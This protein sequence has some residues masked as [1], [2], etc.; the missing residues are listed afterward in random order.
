MCPTLLSHFFVLSAASVVNTHARWFNNSAVLVS[1]DVVTLPESIELLEYLVYV[2]HCHTRQAE[3]GVG[4][5]SQ[6]RFS[7]ES[8]H[9]LVTGF[10]PHA[11]Y[12]LSVT[13]LIMDFDGTVFETSNSSKIHVFVPGS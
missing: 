4:E 10:T 7:P 13:A 9:G 6:W 2:R 8:N 5:L 3:I 11:W 12:S 1:W